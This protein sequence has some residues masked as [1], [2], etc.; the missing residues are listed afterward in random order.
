MTPW[1][2][3]VFE[4]LFYRSRLWNRHFQYDPAGQ[5]SKVR[6]GSNWGSIQVCIPGC[7]AVHRDND[8]QGTSR[9]CKQSLI[10]HRYRWF[11]PL[12]RPHNNNAILGT[13]FGCWYTFIVFFS[14]CTEH[15]KDRP[16]IHQ[17]KEG[18]LW[19]SDAITWRA[20]GP[21]TCTHSSTRQG[22]ART[23]TVRECWTN[24]GELCKKLD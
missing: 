7:A 6:T 23:E 1:M 10:V 22:H 21:I 2:F 14:A 15:I 4:N 17:H 16:G 5:R 9:A 13:G 24:E 3:F 11:P 20:Y 19:A 8:N 18:A 12:G